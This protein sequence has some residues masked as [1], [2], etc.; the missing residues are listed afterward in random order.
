[1]REL[2]R[3][4]RED[5]LIEKVK[6]RGIVG[7]KKRWI[8]RVEASEIKRVETSSQSEKPEEQAKPQVEL[9]GEC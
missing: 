9:E 1:M 5:K 4:L 7:V 2:T 6:M 8:E 3:A